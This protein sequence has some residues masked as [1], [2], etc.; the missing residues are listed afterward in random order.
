MS[1]PINLNSEKNSIRSSATN[2]PVMYVL[3]AVISVVFGA[4]LLYYWYSF[5]QPLQVT[6]ERLQQLSGADVANFTQLRLLGT[7]GSL[8]TVNG[9]W[10]LLQ[11][12]DNSWMY[13]VRVL[14]IP[15]RG[16]AFQQV[17]LPSRTIGVCDLLAKAAYKSFWDQHQYSTNYPDP[18]NRS[19]ICPFSSGAYFLRSVP[20]IAG[21]LLWVG[22]PGMYRMDFCLVKDG[23]LRMIEALYFKVQVVGGGYY[24]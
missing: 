24:Y 16:Q 13:S 5:R 20:L 15:P 1:N 18:K 6:F 21:D 9:S 8:Q 23:V 14:Y 12:L 4:L 7:P 2:Q 10:E 11:D 22:R 3:P 19:A 17:P